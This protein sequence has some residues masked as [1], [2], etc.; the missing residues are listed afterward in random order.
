MP[1]C[2]YCVV[3]MLCGV[4]YTVMVALGL[5]WVVFEVRKTTGIVT[6]GVVSALQLAQIQVFVYCLVL[7][8]LCNGRTVAC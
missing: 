5:T 3:W 4:L 7:V 2:V 6:G 1:G 8:R